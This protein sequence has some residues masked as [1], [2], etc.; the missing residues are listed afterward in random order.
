MIIIAA[1]QKKLT[2]WKLFEIYYQMINGKE[3]EQ[4]RNSRNIV[5]DEWLVDEDGDDAYADLED[6]LACED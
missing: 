1:Q 3:K 6:F 5:I 2:L 4:K